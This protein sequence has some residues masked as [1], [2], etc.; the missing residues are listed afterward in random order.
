MF[1][2]FALLSLL[3]C[4]SF[5]LWL[6]LR[7][8]RGFL[9]LI[10][11]IGWCMNRT[12][13]L[14]VIAST[15]D[16]RVLVIK[17]KNPSERLQKRKTQGTSFRLFTD[18]VTQ[19]SSVAPRLVWN[20]VWWING[21]R[22]LAQHSHIHTHFTCVCLSMQILD[23][24]NVMVVVSRWYGG[25]LLGPDRFKHINNCARNILVEEGFAASTVRRSLGLLWITLS[26]STD[27]SSVKL[28]SALSLLKMENTWCPVFCLTAAPCLSYFY[29]K[30]KVRR[31]IVKAQICSDDVESACFESSVAVTLGKSVHVKCLLATFSADQ[32]RSRRFQQPEVRS[33]LLWSHPCV[34]QS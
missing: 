8:F 30:K 11:S 17:K 12:L 22:S 14:L 28:D 10:V 32:T 5:Y 26:S 20:A 25:I 15:S 24:R 29:T 33:S 34:L 16:K 27:T 2:Y 18:G 6:Y 9:S 31:N 3:H 4:L 13:N 7:L 19:D 1:S 21:S 23:V